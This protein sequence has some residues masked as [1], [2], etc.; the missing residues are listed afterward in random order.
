MHLLTSDVT[1]TTRLRGMGAIVNS[2]V[3]LWCV[4]ILSGWGAGGEL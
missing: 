4:L 2:R 3:G 1:D